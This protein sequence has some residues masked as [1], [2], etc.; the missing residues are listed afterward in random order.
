M[1]FLPPYLYGGFTNP[2]FKKCLPLSTTASWQAHPNFNFFEQ[3][4]IERP[5]CLKPYNDCL[6]NLLTK[7]ECPNFNKK[8]PTCLFTGS[9]AKLGFWSFCAQLESQLQ[10]LMKLLVFFLLIVWP[11]FVTFYF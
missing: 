2:N 8:C 7:L 10:F 6:D 11:K 4:L 5:T 1:G 9:R 3:F